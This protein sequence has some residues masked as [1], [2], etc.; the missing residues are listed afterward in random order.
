MVI[1][2]S[3]WTALSVEHACKYSQLQ[4]LTGCSR[5][6]QLT[7]CSRKHISRSTSKTTWLHDYTNHRGLALCFDATLGIKARRS[8]PVNTHGTPIP[9][10]KAVDSPEEA[11]QDSNICTTTTEQV[12]WTLTKWN[13]WPSTVHKPSVLSCVSVQIRFR[14][15]RPFGEEG[16]AHQQETSLLGRASSALPPLNLRFFRFFFEDSENS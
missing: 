6:Q 8:V 5:K 11:P 14:C 9:R 15:S 16:G 1:T 2:E 12:R 3:L 13:K 4:Q 7:G 10:R